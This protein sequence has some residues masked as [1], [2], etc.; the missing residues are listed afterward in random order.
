M[1]KRILSLLLCA[2]MLI[3]MMLTGCGDSGYSTVQLKQ[4][5]ITLTIYTI[6]D[7]KTTDE[8]LK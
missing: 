6:T 1:K 3:P 4:N 7:E 5:P 2:V 8:G